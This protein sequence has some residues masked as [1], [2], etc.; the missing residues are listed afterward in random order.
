MEQSLDL[1]DTL[2]LVAG[3]MVILWTSLRFSRRQ[4][5]APG[6]RAAAIGMLVWLLL[7]G[8]A[9]YLVFG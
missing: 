4:P 9:L 3:L 5:A 1:L 2:V 6:Q 7:L 8:F